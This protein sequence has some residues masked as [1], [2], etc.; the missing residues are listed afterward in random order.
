M[1]IGI[2]I[3]GILTDFHT[4]LIDYGS[5]YF[6]ENDIPVSFKL[7]NYKIN[8]LFNLEGQ[9]Y[10]SFWREMFNVYLNTAYVRTF[11]SEVVNKL[12]L[13]GN[14]IYII[15]ARNQSDSSLVTTEEMEIATK[16]WLD[17][18]GIYYDS[19]HYAKESKVPIIKELSIDVMIDDQMDNIEPISELIPVICL[20]AP[21]NR[22]ANIKNLYRCYSWY[23]IYKT[24]KEINL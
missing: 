2:D 9:Y 11:A 21:Y 19:I 10:D 20:D 13:E 4:W 15:T 7:D 16:N 1:N 8:D 6:Y 3:D 17:K 12:K 5:K 14:N 22:D 24:I 18:N 23:D